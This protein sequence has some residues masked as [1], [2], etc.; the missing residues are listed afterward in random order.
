[1]NGIFG[2]NVPNDLGMT[3]H[4]CGRR[5]ILRRDQLVWQR[6]ISKTW[7]LF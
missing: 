7:F 6:I 1:M 3:K 5:L 4:K 2:E